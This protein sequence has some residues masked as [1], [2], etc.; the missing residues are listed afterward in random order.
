MFFYLWSGGVGEMVTIA[1][2]HRGVALFS[3]LFE[4]LLVV[5]G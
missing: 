5:V 2:G 4:L 1:P 3:D